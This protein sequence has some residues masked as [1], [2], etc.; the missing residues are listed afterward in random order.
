MKTLLAYSAVRSGEDPVIPAL[1]SALARLEV[2][3]AVTILKVT[4]KQECRVRELP[5]ASAGFDLVLLFNA[6]DWLLANRLSIPGDYVSIFASFCMEDL[7]GLLRDPGLATCRVA[8]LLSNCY[9]VARVQR[10]P[11]PVRYCLKPIL[12]TGPLPEARQTLALLGCVIP[13]LADRDFSLIAW[14]QRKLTEKHPGHQ[15]TVVMPDTVSTALGEQVPAAPERKVKSKREKA[16]AEKAQLDAAVRRLGTEI[17]IARWADGLMSEQEAIGLLEN[18]ECAWLG[19]FKHLPSADWF[20]RCEGPKTCGCYAKEL[21]QTTL[22]DQQYMQLLDLRKVL[23][24]GASV[25]LL[26]EVRH[27][28][29]SQI[30]R[31]VLA[32]VTWLVGVRWINRSV[33]L[34]GQ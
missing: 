20:M 22:T 19:G 27:C 2:N 18:A 23:P 14:V 30:R 24:S 8:G 28:D 13:N 33:S 32:R 4:G 17:Q 31:H 6:A 21:D 9:P 26:Q 10:L 11:F 34:E 1:A 25:R 7:C 12:E 5:G 16:A 3:N 29:D 15:V